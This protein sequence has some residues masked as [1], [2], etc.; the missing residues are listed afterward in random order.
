MC[1]ENY[2][3]LVKKNGVSEK[4]IKKA[5]DKIY[6]EYLNIIKDR[7]QFYVM[8]LAKEISLIEFKITAI[9][10]CIT[11]LSVKKDE[12]V[13][14]ALKKLIPIYGQFDQ[15]NEEKYI[16]DLQS[17]INQSKRF[18]IE[19][20]SKNIEL[21]KL[22]PEDKSKV[23]RDYF[24]QIIWQLSKFTKYH[25]DKYKITVSEFARGM[26]DMRSMNEYLIRQQNER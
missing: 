12:D 24:D 6:D 7:E 1:D 10:L 25:I 16:N 22:I 2:H 15:N 23:T 11:F 13:L 8:T 20:E 4:E 21:N 14:N 5:W 3:V 18:I 19:L 9:N 17:V 26:A